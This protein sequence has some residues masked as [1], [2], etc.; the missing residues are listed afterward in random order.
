MEITDGVARISASYGL[1]IP[2][3]GV[4]YASQDEHI[5]MSVEFPVEG[6]FAA[7]EEQLQ[8]L[9]VQLNA[10]VKL[11]VFGELGVEFAEDDQGVLTPKVKAKPAA[12][13]PRSNGNRRSG[14][15]TRKPQGNNRRGGG[16]ADLSKLPKFNVTTTD[17]DDVTIIDLRSLKKNGT[18]KTTAADFKVDGQQ[19]SFWLFDKDGNPND[20][21]IDWLIEQAV[22]TEEDVA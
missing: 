7:I 13:A 6:D 11:A 15:N 12:A 20:E 22:I 17:G 3:E 16:G 4:Q 9:R 18:Y 8:A 2:L 5:S 10:N 14:G 1:K 21:T 19:V